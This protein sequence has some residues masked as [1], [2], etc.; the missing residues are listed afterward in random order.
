MCPLTIRLWCTALLL[1]NI[2]T[3]PIPT[4]ATCQEQLSRG[5]RESHW[6]PPPGALGV[7]TGAIAIGTAATSTSTTTII[8][9]GTTTRTSTEVKLVRGTDGSTTRNTVATR[10]TATEE[11]R[12]SSVVRVL[13]EPVI[14]AVPEDLVVPVARAALAVPEDPVVPVARAALAALANRVA[15]VALAVRVVLAELANRVALAELAV[16][17]VLAELANPVALAELAVR[18]APVALEL[19]PVVAVPERDQV[20]AQRRTK[21]ATAA[22]HHGQVRVPKRAEDLAAVAAATMHAPAVTEAATAWEAAE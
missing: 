19:V 20:E 10:R 18:V 12:T 3:I 16:R 14:A 15:S 8:S 17:V 5:E 13:A 21:S 1:L 11:P 7:V 4:P 6:G 9:T 22:H 2:L